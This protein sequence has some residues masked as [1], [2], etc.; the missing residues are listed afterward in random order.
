MQVSTKRFSVLPIIFTCILSVCLLMLASCTSSTDQDFE[1]TPPPY[2]SP[3][4]FSGLT[5]VNDRFAYTEDGVIRSKTGIDVSEYQGTIDWN[6]VAGDGI[7]FAFIR[8]GNRGATEGALSVDSQFEVNMQG[9]GDAGIPLGVYFFSQAITA[10]EAI[11]EA[12][13]VLTNLGG[14]ALTYPIVYDHEPVRGIE[15]ARANNLSRA[16]ATENARA[17]C[18]R[19]AQAG[20]ETMI[21]GNKSDIARLDRT[22]LEG[23]DIWFAEYDAATPSGQFDFS[24]WQYTNNAIVAG[25]STRVDMNIEFITAP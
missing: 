15:N 18:D 12:E 2:E 17:F 5:S 11:E 19:I 22:A 4:D 3:Y 24:I 1:P 21:Y 20:Y 9:A 8:L 13:F 10:Q 6:A 16:Q 14:R 23:I 25:I 7:G